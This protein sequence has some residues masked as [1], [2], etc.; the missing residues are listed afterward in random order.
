M[1]GTTEEEYK[2]KLLWNVKREV[3][4]AE[5]HIY[6]LTVVFALTTPITVI[7]LL[8][9]FELLGVF[10]RGTFTAGVQFASASLAAAELMEPNNVNVS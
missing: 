5:L 2:E 1:E 8:V 7:S 3:G 10:F 9:F 6:I 4:A